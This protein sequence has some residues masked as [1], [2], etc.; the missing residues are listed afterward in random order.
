LDRGIRSPSSAKKDAKKKD[1]ACRRQDFE[2]MRLPV[3][4][5]GTLF[6]AIQ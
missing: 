2:H 1:D 4:R 6:Q 5:G 3:F